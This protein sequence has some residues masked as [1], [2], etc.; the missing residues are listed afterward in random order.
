MFRHSKYVDITQT[1][2]RETAIVAC[3]VM[4]VH[5][6]CGATYAPSQVRYN[7]LDARLM[8]I[9]VLMRGRS[10]REFV[11]VFNITIIIVIIIITLIGSIQCEYV[12]ESRTQITESGGQK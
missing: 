7:V 8:Y 6:V 11:F 3:C 2:L 10:H 4:P 9:C 1:C 12:S 5:R